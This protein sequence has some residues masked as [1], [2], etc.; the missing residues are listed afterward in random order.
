MKSLLA[1][2]SLAG[3]F[4]LQTPSVRAD[5]VVVEERLEEHAS[6]TL[7]IP[8][9][10]IFA[11]RFRSD[12]WK[13]VRLHVESATSDADGMKYSLVEDRIHEVSRPVDASR[14]ELAE[15]NRFLPI[16]G[17]RLRRV[18]LRVTAEGSFVLRRVIAVFQH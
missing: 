17:S 16:P 1:I 7:F 6:R 3:F 10:Q 8:L 9:H 13:L 15:L 14:N 18:E 11:P 5:E 12:E 2:L 4:S